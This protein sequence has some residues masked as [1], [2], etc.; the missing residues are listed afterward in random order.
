[1]PLPDHPYRAS[2][3]INCLDAETKKGHTGIRPY[4]P[5][6]ITT[7]YIRYSELFINTIFLFQIIVN[8]YR[9]RVQYCHFILCKHIFFLLSCEYGFLIDIIFFVGQYIVS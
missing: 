3:Y 6:L 8:K 9:E 7:A 1:M 4:R 2:Q 5:M